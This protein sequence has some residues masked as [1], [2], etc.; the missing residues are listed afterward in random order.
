ME[1]RFGRYLGI[2]ALG[3]GILLISAGVLMTPGVAETVLGSVTSLSEERTGYLRE[4]LHLLRPSAV[5]TGI[6][7]AIG[8]V[9]LLACPSTANRLLRAVSGLAEG[10]WA[11]YLYLLSCLMLFLA[12][13]L[14]GLLVTRS[15]TGISPDSETYIRTGESIYHGNGLPTD[16]FEPPLYPLSIAGLMHV[17]ISAEQAAKFVP[18]LCFALMMFPL[19]VLGKR[20]NNTFT[21]FAACFMCLILAPLLFVTS[22]AWTEMPYIFL[23]VLA[24]LFLAKFAQSASVETGALCL[25]GL[26][27][28]LALLTRYIGCTVVLT[29]LIVIVIKNKSQPIRLVCQASIFGLI[30]CLPTVP[31]LYRNI[32]VTH[33]L[34]GA[35][36][37][38]AVRST[39]GLPHNLNRIV[40]TIRGDFLGALGIST[41][42]WL[43]FISY[44]GLVVAVAW[45]VLLGFHAVRTQPSGSGMLRKWLIGNHVA[46]LYISVYLTTLVLA[47]TAWAFNE[48]DTRLASPA[49]PFLVLVLVSFVIYACGHVARS[50]LRQTLFLVTVIFSLLFI[51]F[52]MSISL[53]FYLYAKDGQGY[54]SPFWRNNQ[55]IGWVAG[56]VSQNGVLYCNEPVALQFWVKRPILNLPLSGD[57]KG[58]ERLCQELEEEKDSFIVCFKGLAYHYSLAKQSG[59]SNSEL[60]EMNRECHDVFVVVADFP[61]GTVWRVQAGGQ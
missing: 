10:R 31:M 36:H 24:I 42:H 60:T 4:T 11:K 20:M 27:T 57:Q 25:A 1:H 50:S 34:A 8:G 52:Q 55:A 46:I 39:E 17:G 19:F 18:I 44:T 47:R 59:S 6:L 43:S 26:F 3:I 54:N 2:A 51:A 56:N 12:A 61:D 14:F 41:P 16:I 7:V 29:G 9:L 58:L 49:Y 45:L 15:G 13:L 48:I 40:E 37:A 30:A 32:T 53:G 23:S 35:N 38:T 33:H 21:G 28:A 5:F 22:F